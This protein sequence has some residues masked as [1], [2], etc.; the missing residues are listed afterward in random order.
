MAC[1]DFPM[2][3]G[4]IHGDRTIV[5][6]IMHPLIKK[7]QVI[8]TLTKYYKNLIMQTYTLQYAYSN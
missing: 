7:L 6:W 1:G 3:T 5:T 8:D 2:M 4:R